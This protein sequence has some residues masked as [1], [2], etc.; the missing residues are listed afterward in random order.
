ML[1]PASAISV[2]III[3]AIVTTAQERRSLTLRSMESRVHAAKNQDHVDD[4][5]AANMHRSR[6]GLRLFIHASIFWKTQVFE[7]PAVSCYFVDL[8]KVCRTEVI[9]LLG[10]CDKEAKKSL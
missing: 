2:I 3:S 9:E 6:R 4:G 7:M 8:V 1:P 10:R 5:P